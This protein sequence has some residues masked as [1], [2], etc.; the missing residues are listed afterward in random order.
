[1]RIK[2]EKNIFQKP[3]VLKKNFFFQT[4]IEKNFRLAVTS[5]ASE[6]SFKIC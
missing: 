3:D 1:M 4:E 2:K 6:V 5:M